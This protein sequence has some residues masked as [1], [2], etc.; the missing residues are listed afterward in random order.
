MTT[1]NTTIVND[2]P[3]SAFIDSPPPYDPRDDKPI[4]DGSKPASAQSAPQ[5]Q[6]TDLMLAGPSIPASYGAIM[7]P[8]PPP[9]HQYRG[10]NG[11][12]I[13]GLLPPNHPEMICLQQGHDPETHYGLLGI[14]AAIFWFPLGIG[15]C[16]L[17]RRVKCPSHGAV[18]SLAPLALAQRRARPQ[19]QMQLRRPD[20]VLGLGSRYKNLAYSLDFHGSTMFQDPDPQSGLGGWGASAA[21]D[22]TITDGAFSANASFIMAY[23]VLHSIRRHFDLYPYLKSLQPELIPNPSMPGNMSITPSL[24]RGII[25]GHVGDF[26]GFQAA[27]EGFQG[28]HSAVHLMVGGDLA[29]TCPPNAPE[30]CKDG[31]KWAPNDPLFWMHHAMIDKVWSEWQSKHEANF[32]SFEGGSVQRFENIT[33]HER[34]PNGGPPFLHVSVLIENSALSGHGLFPDGRIADVMNTTGGYLCYV[35]E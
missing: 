15:L 5:L 20:A 26:K 16:M 6:P 25:G 7:V 19:S 8:G 33:I 32:M 28:P 23:P 35:Y 13:Y 2:T 18:L 17:D 34:Y 29:G 31:S 30:E 12:I 9:V 1:P 22:Y 4:G 24:I 14:L 21:D 10:P 11:E 27:F 3:P